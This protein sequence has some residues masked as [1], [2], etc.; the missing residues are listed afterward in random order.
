MRMG[1][2]AQDAVGLSWQTTSRTGGSK[3]MP[4]FGRAW[5]NRVSV[6]RDRERG[7]VSA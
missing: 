1:C 4:A 7:K 6:Q 3:A 2:A 5:A